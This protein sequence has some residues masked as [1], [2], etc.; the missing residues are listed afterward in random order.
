MRSK[1]L[2]LVMI[3]V[4]ACLLLAPGVRANNNTYTVEDEPG[5]SCWASGTGSFFD[6]TYYISLTRPETDVYTGL[7]FTGLNVSEAEIINNATL[8][9]YFDLEFEGNSTIT[10]YGYDQ[11]LGSTYFSSASQ[12]RSSPLTSNSLT[13]DLSEYNSSGYRS[14]DVTEI[15]QEIVNRPYWLISNNL[16]FVILGAEGQDHR[17]I[18][19]NVIRPSQWPELYL[20]W[21]EAPDSGE[22]GSYVE[23]YRGYEIFSTLDPGSKMALVSNSTSTYILYY[24]VNSYYSASPGWELI[25]VNNSL[26]VGFADNNLGFVYNG[27]VYTLLLN[28]TDYGM[29]LSKAPIDSM[30]EG[31]T[32]VGEFGGSTI[33]AGSSLC[34]HEKE[35]VVYM[36]ANA[37]TGGACYWATYDIVNENFTNRGSMY[38]GYSTGTATTINSVYDPVNEK[39]LMAFSSPRTSGSANA[40]RLYNCSNEENNHIVSFY[41]DS[42]ST[43]YPHLAI[44]GDRA[45][46]F[47]HKYDSEYVSKWDLNDIYTDTD[48]NT[49]HIHGSAGTSITRSMGTTFIN[50]STYAVTYVYE[51]PNDDMR[52]VYF[53]NDGVFYDRFETTAFKPP[54]QTGYFQFA[55]R[56]GP[57]DHVLV[58]VKSS[59]P[60]NG[61]YELPSMQSAIWGGAYDWDYSDFWSHYKLNMDGDDMGTNSYSG[62]VDFLGTGEEFYYIYLNGTLIG[63]S[64]SIDDA[65]DQIDDLL[66][67][68]DPLDPDPGDWP[69][70]PILS[71]RRFVFVFLI[72]GGSLVTLPWIYFAYNR[73]PESLVIALFLTTIG[74]ALLWSIPGL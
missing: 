23:Q 32:V 54:D 47:Y 35:N 30:D 58:L 9:L 36:W 1:V 24:D 33:M 19:S 61:F 21:G 2:K 51:A 67:G 66:G 16:G 22:E 25:P 52:Y 10:I 6:S 43:Y 12:L 62:S 8:T 70:D 34:L 71:K 26:R 60:H 44:Y 3:G 68:S 59:S 45:Y 53:D 17:T 5:A 74:L 41:D 4:L 14:F 29:V 38:G 20:E 11:D 27:F 37:Q 69:E 55:Q 50:N 28:S 72:T 56:I 7:V 65:K 39:I 49:Q 48:R 63:N 13:V 42:V 46:L 73:R 15:V 40:I 18:T 57:N 31:F 64:T